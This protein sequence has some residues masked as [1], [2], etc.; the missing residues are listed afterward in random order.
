MEE[1]ISDPRLIAHV[2]DVHDLFSVIEEPR[3]MFELNEEKRKRYFICT[4]FTLTLNKLFILEL[5]EIPPCFLQE[6]P[7][8][9]FMETASADDIANTIYD[10][11]CPR[12]WACF[13][14]L[15]EGK[16]AVLTDQCEL[17]EGICRNYK[18]LAMYHQ[19]DK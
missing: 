19:D 5:E 8:R 7:A 18:I 14:R 13:C 4:C 17:I 16:F 1:K 3:L 10:M 9:C 11:R 12:S 6:D 2:D 15:P